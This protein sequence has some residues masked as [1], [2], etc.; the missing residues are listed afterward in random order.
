MS[1]DKPS[2]AE[3]GYFAREEAA[4]RQRA[5][6]EENK[7][8]AEAERERRKQLH[9][10]K[11]PKCGMDLAETTFRGVTIDKC[12]GCGYLGFDDKEIELL[13]GHEHPNLFQNIANIFRNRGT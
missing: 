12:Y 7:Q 8:L 10:M 3:Q 1:V 13:L 9:F 6:L 2:E 11:C 5:A 4:R